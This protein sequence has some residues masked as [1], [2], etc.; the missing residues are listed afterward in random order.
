M[1]IIHNGIKYELR[2]EEN[3]AYVMPNEYKGK[4]VIPAQIIV[5]GLV[6]KCNWHRRRCVL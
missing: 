1:E 5:D 6:N 3:G 4:V 2:P